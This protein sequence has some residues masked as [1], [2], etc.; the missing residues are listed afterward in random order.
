MD[1]IG[2]LTG[3]AGAIIVIKDVRIATFIWLTSNIAFV[4]WGLYTGT[5]SIIALNAIY[6]IINSVTLII[7]WRK[8]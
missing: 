3:I 5:L 4:C 1:W 8:P 6:F 2:T 7:R